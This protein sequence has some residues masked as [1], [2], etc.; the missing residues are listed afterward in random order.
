MLAG[1]ICE[2]KSFKKIEEGE[3]KESLKKKQAII[4]SQIE[5][6]STENISLLR[7]VFKIHPT[8]VEDV[9]SEQTPIKYEEFED[10]KVI[11]FKGIQDI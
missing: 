1:Y 2:P 7:D 9:F 11:I 6:A 8:T 4:W 10:Y 5:I 3:I